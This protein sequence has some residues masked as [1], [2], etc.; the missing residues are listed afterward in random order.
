MMG[1]CTSCG[2]RFDFSFFCTHR[3]TL[4]FLILS[5]S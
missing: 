3:T 5:L 4:F 1:I 2:F